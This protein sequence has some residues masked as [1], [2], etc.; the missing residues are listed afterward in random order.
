MDPALLAAIRANMTGLRPA[1]P[2]DAVGNA[3]CGSSFDSPYSAGGLFVNLRTYEGCGADFV[4]ADAAKS[5]CALY[6]HHAWRKAPRADAAATEAKAAPT[7][8]GVGVDGGFE[9]E[10]AKYDVVKTRSLAVV[11]D[12]AVTLVPLP[13]DAVPDFVAACATAALD[14]EGADPRGNKKFN[15][16]SMCDVSALVHALRKKHACSNTES[17]T[18]ENDSSKNQQLPRREF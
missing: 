11:R 1:G 12:G 14:A 8:L 17:S 13:D 18:T 6:A 3:E 16:N 10:D 9:A 5:G 4:A 15:P 2:R 7:T